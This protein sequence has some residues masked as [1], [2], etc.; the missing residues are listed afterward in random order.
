MIQQLVFYCVN[1]CSRELEAHRLAGNAE[2]RENC[3]ESSPLECVT[4]KVCPHLSTVST[5]V[6]GSWRII[7]LLEMQ[8]AM[9]TAESPH[10]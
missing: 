4:F 8:R 2:S 3:R 1:P 5:H 9:K 7:G 6:L 10:L